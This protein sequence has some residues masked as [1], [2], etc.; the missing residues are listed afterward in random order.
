MYKEV[1]MSLKIEFKLSNFDAFRNKLVSA[2]DAVRR[3]KRKMLTE[4]AMIAERRSKI[5]APVD[6]NVLRGSITSRVSDDEAVIGTNIKYAPHQEYGTGVYGKSGTPI[7]PKRGRFLVFKVGGRTIFARSVRGSKGHF[8]MKKALD[9]VKTRMKDIQ[10]KANEII[11]SL[12][13]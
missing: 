8:Y 4:G 11:D 9:E 6:K 13:F 3:V 12:K 7:R 2:P 1:S 5:E 10:G